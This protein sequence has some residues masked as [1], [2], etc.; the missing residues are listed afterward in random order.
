VTNLFWGGGKRSPLLEIIGNLDIL[1]T[2]GCQKSGSIAQIVLGVCGKIWASS[3]SIDRNL[4]WYV[5][6]N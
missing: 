5:L 2:V 6:K 3:G 4:L 1:M